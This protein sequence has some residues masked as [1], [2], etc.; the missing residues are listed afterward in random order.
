M[1]VIPCSPKKIVQFP[2]QLTQVGV[3][4]PTKAFATTGLR[5]LV[6]VSVTPVLMRDTG[7]VLYVMNA[8]GASGA[9]A[10]SSFASRI[11]LM[12]ATGQAPAETG[13]TAMGS[14]TA[15]SATQAVIAPSTAL[16]A[17]RLHATS[18]AGAYQTTERVSVTGPRLDTG[19]EKRVTSA[20]LVI[21][22]GHAI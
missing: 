13:L 16:E 20:C 17:R 2:V 1:S 10:A 11:S 19:M 9:Q 15:T 8:C 12:S 3:S 5:A 4:A 21:Q 7:R 14:V 22:D 6:T 18:T